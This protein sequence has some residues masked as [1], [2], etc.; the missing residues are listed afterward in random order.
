[1]STRL[2][3]R[4]AALAAAASLMAGCGSGY[5]SSAENKTLE[6]QLLTMDALADDKVTITIRA[7]YNV[8]N[9]VIRKALQDQ[10]PDTNIVMV[11]HCSQKTQ[12]ELRQSLQGG[13]AEDIIISPNMKQ[14]ADLA[15]NTMID[16]SQ[17]DYVERYKGES[18]ADSTVNGKVYYLPGPSSI[19]GIVY[20]RTL[21]AAQGWEIPHSYDEFLSL[22]STIDAS[23]IRAF[24]PSCKYARQAQMVFTMFNYDATF[25]GTDHYNWLLGYQS[26]QNGMAGFMEPALERYLQLQQAD[27]IR[28]DDFDVQPGNRSKMIYTDHTAA[29]IIETQ[30]AEEYAAQAGSD[31]EYGML[32]FWSGNE[33]DSDYVMS[34]PS[35]YI[36]LNKSLENKGNA[37]K[38]KKAKEIL[39]Y[40]STPE[41]QLAISGGTMKQ[42]SNVEDTSFPDTDFLKEVKSTILAGRAVPEIDLMASGNNNAAELAL[43]KDLRSLLEG[44]IDAAALMKDCDDARN[45]ALASGSSA[46][47][48]VIA[49]A[50]KTFSRIETGLFIADA[51]RQKA[52][53]DI[54]LCLC[55]TVHCG[56]VGQ[57]YQGDIGT[58]DIKSL[59]LSVGTASA[60][61]NDKKLWLVELTGDQLMNLL[62]EGYQLNP[63]DNVPNLPYYVASGL[64]IKFAPLKEDRLESVTLADG[65]ALNPEVTYQVALWGWPFE[66]PCAGRILKVFDDSCDDILIEAFKKQGSVS[67]ANEGAFTVDLQ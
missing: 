18:L 16:L 32:P 43:Q 11:F 23:G 2:Q 59:S 20:D 3:R 6:S 33:E 50:E 57:I 22:V 8:N 30:S 52:D 47:G 9:E 36:G 35:Y 13:T 51:L 49:S 21:F 55:G 29:M 53:A 63:N 60:D 27:V 45:S 1:M 25:S 34:I 10:F 67:P 46:N 48:E 62:Q 42:I 28:A 66:Q 4:I 39:S 41:G 26:G 54:G 24:Q 64:K 31:H 19:Y 12:Y 17:E 40:I 44:T 7:E 38:L 58:E 14:A 61:P 65:S 37:E 56:M 15:P 5:T